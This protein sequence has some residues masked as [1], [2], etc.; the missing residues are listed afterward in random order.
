MVLEKKI[1]LRF[2]HYKSMGALYR[3]GRATRITEIPEYN[4]NTGNNCKKHILKTQV[5]AL[6]NYVN[7]MEKG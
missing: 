6:I 5:L 3:H 2:S 4:Q 7:L 1:F